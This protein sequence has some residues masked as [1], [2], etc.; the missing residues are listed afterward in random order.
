[1]AN[2][3]TDMRR[4]WVNVI[5]NQLVWLCAVA[6]AGRGWQ[7]PAVLSATLYVASQLLASSRPRLELRLLLLALG[8]AWL[9]DGSA[10]ASGAVQYAAAP[11]GWMPPPWIFA[12]WAAFAMTLTA[13]MAFLQRHWM[14]PVALGLLAPLA[15]LSAARGFQAVHF[16]SPAWLGVATL[17]LGWCVALSLLCAVARRGTPSNRDTPLIG[18]A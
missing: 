4:T 18:A 17:A 5:G 1:M 2:G 13:S 8:C 6:G 11:H 15:Y 3:P 14:L 10:A 16:T 12:L 7:W 9:V